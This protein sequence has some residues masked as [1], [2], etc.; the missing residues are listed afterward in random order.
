MGLGDE[1]V[2]R[3]ARVGAT[4]AVGR[5]MPPS[6][7]RG[8]AAARKDDIIKHSSFLGAL[9]GVVVGA[10]IGA[11]VFAVASAV[12]VGTGGL[13]TA[14][15]L[16]LGT[17]G[18]IALGGFISDVSSAVTN[19]IDSAGPPDGVISNGS[20]NVLIEGKPAARATVDLAKCSQHPP[21]L[22]AQGSES[23]F[24][25]GEPAAR[26]DDKLVCG[27]TIKS[28]A[29]KVFIG[30]G[31]GTYLKIEEEFSGWQRALLIAV[32][33]IVPP[34]RGLAKGIGKLFTKAGQKA[35]VRGAVKGAKK[36][37][38]IIRGQTLKCAKAAFK[39]TKGLKRYW[40]STKKFF[41]GDP[42]DV[43]TGALF[44]QRTD[45]ELGQTLPLLFTRSWSPGQRG[46]LGENWFDN[47]SE[48]ALVT[49]DRV[50]ILTTEGAS[51]HFALPQSVN[52]SINPEHPEF[53]LSREKSGF[54]LAERN[55]PVR[56]YF[57]R[58]V[59]SEENTIQR[60]L[61]TEHRDNNGNAVHFHYHDTHRLEKVTHS[62]GPELRLFYRED[63]LLEAI[64]RTDNGLNDVMARYGY[65]DNGWLAEADSIQQFHLFYEYNEQG[66]ISRWSDDDQ[67]A[68]DY[69]YDVQGRCIHSVG[70]GG[71]YP[72]QLTYEPG[73]TRSTTPQGHT[74]SWHYNDQQQVT[75][76]ETPCGHITRYEYDEWGN[77][78]H[79]ILPEGQTLTLD[80]LADTGLVTQ[81][82]DAT[83][84]TWQYHYDNLD[85]LIS[86][87]DPLG[88]VWWQ[89]Y[90]N[91]G[92]AE[93][94]IAPDGSK[95]TL[96]R[97][98]FGLVIAAEDDDG[99]KRTWEYDE[100]QRL[101][102]LFD[103][104][105]RSLRLGYDSHDRLQRLSSG[106]GAL[107]L[108]EYDRHHRVSLS[109]RPNNSLER[110]RHDRHGNLTDWTDARGVKWHIEYG[111]FD[112]PVARVDGEG[113]RWQ[114][115]YDLDSLQLL[116]VINPLGESYSYT[117]DADGRVITETD[118]AGT[119]WHYTY[120]GNGNC[121]EK[122]DA[123]DNITRYEY[124][125]A[126]RMTA[127]HTPEGT[128]TY[129]YDILG[130][131]LEITAP[132]SVP[133]TFEYDDKDR[134]I[135][136]TQIHGKIQR[137]YPDNATVKRMLYTLDGQHWQ[138]QAE[139][140]K[141]GELRLLSLSDEH[142]LSLER[143]EDGHEWH[144][145]S[146][147]GF[148]LRQEHSLMGQL[149]TQ[150]AGRNTEF[151]EAHEVADIPQPTLAGLDREYRY[152]AALNLVAAN[153]ER[154]CLR[155]VVNGN[156]QVTSVSE[157]ERL[158]EHYQYDA[159]GYPARRFDGLHD[160]D[161]ERL[162]QK[163]HRL[164]Q[165]GQ[166]LFEYDDAGRMTAMQLWQEGH[167]A[168]LTKFRWNS[169]NQLIGVQTPGG[170]Q[171]DYRYDA[172]GRRTEKACE[173]AGLRTTY[174][175][176][177][178]VPAEIREYRHNRL[179]SIR[180]LV[181]DGWQLLAQ[182]VQ[183]FSLNPENRNELIAGK[184]QTQYAVCAPTG[185]PLA[186]FD[187]AGHRVWRQPPQSLYGLRLGVLGENP[188]LNPGLK[189]AGQWLD[190]ESGLV[191]NRFRY[192]SPVVGQ[193]LTPDPI[194][195][196]GGFNPYSYVSNPT[197]LIDPLGLAGCGVALTVNKPKILGTNLS[198]AE[199]K[200]LEREFRI[201][202]NALNR[203]AKRG[204]L[205]WS[206]GTHNVR[207][208]SLQSAYRKALSERYERI[209]GKAPNLSKL[210]ADHPVDL[211]VGGSA[212]QRLK[213]LNES[214]NKSVGSALKSAGR[215]AGL[216]AGDKI[217]EI[218]FI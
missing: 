174:L 216:K 62:D 13:A 122:R 128:T 151:F 82:T 117:L 114:Y 135:K 91:N 22:I 107:W 81:F 196:H 33:F 10:L 23:V 67:T 86:M 55:N 158:R 144:R 42:I 184:I 40:A 99:N 1:I 168:Q 84:A 26:K 30:S 115:H 104:E 34:S 113:H 100:H 127:M 129:R 14:A 120:D 182:Q 65:Y 200:F 139:A 4:H 51:L 38:E 97:N 36:V 7:P 31:Q 43:T 116:E 76:V 157:G 89:Q 164:R 57:I 102:K 29:S 71:F 17:V 28:G 177:G 207:I 5:A 46:L 172:F 48:C 108:W 149:T 35:V 60:W 137:D 9:A 147:K 217:S 142:T 50:E 123:L 202:Q 70:S 90:D 186:L 169:Q 159:S 2:T 11:A 92:N 64:H 119:Q 133:L 112:L 201:K 85:Q 124:D 132:E 53:R 160:I 155:Y 47:F 156:G 165:L 37:G 130:R 93:C 58:L 148:I 193:Y 83:G 179:Y 3:I 138:V 16:A 206:P 211:I 140:N 126:Q 163:G 12:I 27:S 8:P 15:V 68:V 109:D 74:T 87:T 204:E 176:D 121:I 210:N 150:R 146:D 61:L 181:F 49:G 95:T 152:D 75:Q 136:E 6:Q 41:T 66:L 105:N 197:G 88:R 171:W 24:I 195:L 32:E 45:I 52:H 191:Y 218:I 72:V 73:I 208:S 77:L 175:W 54:V 189:F 178:D 194:G 188:E 198:D 162:Y 192:Y 69:T 118:Y 98:K 215:Q 183:F 161:G 212:T 213:M 199:R 180:H 96:I 153:D 56:K 167:R 166:H 44:D 19:M 145:Q 143:D 190:E 141:V 187:T 209:F 170:Q 110:F 80:Y 205:V 154:E 173:R 21:P 106:G 103:E 101:T 134:I 20:P 203:A 78:R 18:T 63:G 59:P 131:L 185:E 111:P 79:Q 214:I 39:E 125:A 94:F 25:N